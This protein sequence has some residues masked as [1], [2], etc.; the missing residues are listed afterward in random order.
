MKI[1]E[2]K[3]KA[4]T[5]QKRRI[6]AVRVRIVDLFGGGCARCGFNDI[7]A[8]QIDHIKGGGNR[9]RK[10]SGSTYYNQVLKSFAANEGKYQILCAN[11][12]WIKRVE[13]NEC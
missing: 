7:R 2:I 3:H 4:R 10:R 13:N 6:Q 12:N 1:E 9:E 11:C 8:L 5:A